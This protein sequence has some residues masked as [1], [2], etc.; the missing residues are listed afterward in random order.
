MAL[1]LESVI[2]VKLRLFGCESCTRVRVGHD[3]L[4]ARSV[5][6]ERVMVRVWVTV[7]VTVRV[8]VRVRGRVR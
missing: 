5:S 4:R 1:V 8:I 2:L 6:H 7:R 3:Q